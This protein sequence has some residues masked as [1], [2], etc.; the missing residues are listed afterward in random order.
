MNEDDACALKMSHAAGKQ[1]KNAS[2]NF[3]QK[4]VNFWPIKFQPK[5]A[6]YTNSQKSDT[7]HTHLSLS[8]SLSLF[9]SFL[10]SKIFS[11]VKRR[12]NDDECDLYVLAR[13]FCGGVFARKR[14]H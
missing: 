12:G 5:F 14:E 1:T 10:C 9:C 8:L 13:Y 4:N 3:E 7:L 6:F 2:L 11:E